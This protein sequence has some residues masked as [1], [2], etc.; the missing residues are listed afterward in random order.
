M[1]YKRDLAN[2]LAETFGPGDKVGDQKNA[3]RSAMIG[4][5]L[6][7]IGAL[8]FGNKIGT[9]KMSQSRAERLKKR[10]ARRTKRKN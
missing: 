5:G 8:I 2:P 3:P 10:E 9:D 1:A 6:A 7:S 4:K